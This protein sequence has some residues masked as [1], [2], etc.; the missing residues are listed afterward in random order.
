MNEDFESA[1]E[2]AELIKSELAEGVDTEEVRG[3]FNR[4]WPFQDNEEI[5]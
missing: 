4:I 1:K 5:D 2:R 3:E